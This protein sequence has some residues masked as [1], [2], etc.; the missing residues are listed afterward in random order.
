M[1]FVGIVGSI[2][3]ARV[4]TF[5]HDYARVVAKSPIELTMADI[6]GP[7]V[8]GTALEKTIRESAGRCAHVEAGPSGHIDRKMIER[9]GELESSTAYVGN[10]L[11]HLDTGVIGDAVAGLRTLLPIDDHLSGQD[12]GLRSFSRFCEPAVHH[13]LIEATFAGSE[14]HALRRTIRSASSRRR[15]ARSSNIFRAR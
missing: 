3:I 14:L 6:D 8:L 5:F 11:E 7:D 10:A 15:S 1:K 4:H 13:E 9:G 12:Q 2:E